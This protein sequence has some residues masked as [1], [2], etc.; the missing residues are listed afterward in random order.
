MKIDFKKTLPSYKAKR[1]V[2]SIVQIP[3]MQYLAIEGGGGPMSQDFRDAIE[4]LY[5]VAYT[6]KFM[7]KTALDRDYVVPPLEALWWAKDWAVFTTKFDQT[8]WDWSAMVMVPNWLTP[9]HYEQAIDKVK[10]KKSP[11]LLD[12]LRLVPLEEQVCVQTLH[13]G[14]FADEGP[15]LKTMH[16]QFIPDHGLALT[17][18][19]HEIYFSDFR[20]TAPE[21]LRTLLR[22][23]V[24]AIVD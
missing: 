10:A 13:I 24:K 22:Q 15:L 17:G 16:E 19:H 20:K 6:L 12:Q 21:K 4:T 7:S 3:A 23:P 1:G 18:K 11:K 5:P 9:S 8:Q 2:F 14:P